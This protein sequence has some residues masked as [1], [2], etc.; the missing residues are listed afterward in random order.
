MRIQWSRLARADVKEIFD[1]YTLKVS[2]QI[3]QSIKRK[4][5]RSVLPLKEFP[6][7]GQIE[8]LLQDKKVKYRYLLEGNY[9]IIYRTERRNVFIITVFDTRRNPE[10]LNVK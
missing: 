8:P 10:T 6:E 1:Y 5:Q 3:A 4:V 2:P 7:M 9:K